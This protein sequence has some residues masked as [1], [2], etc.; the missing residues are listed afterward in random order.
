MSNKTR[1]DSIANNGIAFKRE[2][3]RNIENNQKEEDIVHH[4]NTL[5]SKYRFGKSVKPDNFLSGFF[6][7]LYFVCHLNCYPVCIQAIAIQHD[8]SPMIYIL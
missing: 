4:K 8:I 2:Q 7:L 5:K 3:K 6:F 1:M